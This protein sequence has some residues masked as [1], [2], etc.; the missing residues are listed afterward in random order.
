MKEF[1]PEHFSANE[2]HTEPGKYLKEHGRYKSRK[3]FLLEFARSVF[4]FNSYMKREKD[5]EYV[6]AKCGEFMVNFIESRGGICHIDGLE[7]FR[8][9]KGPFVILGNHMG[10]IETIFPFY[11]AD[12]PLSY[13]VKNSLIR[14]P[15]FNKVLGGCEPIGLT[16]KNIGKDLRTLME[17][18]Q[19]KLAAG[20]SVVLFP[21]GSRYFD[22]DK[23]KFNALGLRLSR[24]A[25]V[26]MVSLAVKTDFIGRGRLMSYIGKI[27]SSKEIHLSF[28]K[29]IEPGK[30]GKDA[31]FAVIEEISAKLKNWGVNVYD[32]RQKGEGP[33]LLKK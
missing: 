9:E 1:S 8:K 16:R 21:A 11:F 15:V 3:T 33:L 5:H 23:A 31:H 22:F 26:P 2:Y 7:I 4:S 14:T 13:V 20:R 24:A 12:I 30:A 10:M 19:K 6:M 29:P 28:G 25:G 17:E 32:S 18:G 27:D